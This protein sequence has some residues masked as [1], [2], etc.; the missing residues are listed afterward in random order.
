MISCHTASVDGNKILL[1]EAGPK[2]V[3]SVLLLH[4]FHTS[5][6]MFRNLIPILAERYHVVAPDLPG[7]GFSDSPDRKKF[8]YTFEHLAK[9]ID[10]F[11]QALGLN[12]Y[13]I[14]VFDYGAP[15]GLRLALAHPE[16]V[17]AT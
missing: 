4:G 5:S 8:A 16:R 13:A 14:Y 1:R 7:F 2:T 10:A 12:R 3:P 17:T 11:T 9:A 6:H 15:V